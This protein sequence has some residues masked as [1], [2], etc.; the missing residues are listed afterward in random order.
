MMKYLAVKE[1][2]HDPAT[3]MYTAWGIK[4]WQTGDRRQAVIAYIPNVF[5]SEREAEYFASLCTQLNLSIF[6]LSDVVEDYLA[7]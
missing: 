4:G 6:R 2:H 7:E 5:H 3:G 1:R